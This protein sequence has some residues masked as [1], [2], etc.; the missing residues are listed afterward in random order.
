MASDEQLRRDQLLLQEQLRDLREAHIKRLHEMEELSGRDKWGLSFPCHVATTYQCRGNGYKRRQVMNNSDEIHYLFTNNYQNK[1]SIFVKLISKV[2]MRWK[3][4]GEF[5]NYESMN[6]REEDW[7]KIKTLS[8]NS[9]PEFRNFRMKLIVWMIREILRMLNQYAADYPTFSI[10]RSYFH[11]IVILAGC[12]AAMISRQTYGIR[13]VYRETFFSNP[14][15]S[16]SS[17]YPGGF[18]PWIR[19]V[20][21]HISPRAT[22]ER[23]TPDTALDPRCHSGPSARNS[24]NSN[25]GRFS[26][27]HGA[28]QQRL[29]IS[30]PHYDKFPDQQR[31]LDGRQD[32]R[33]RYVLVHNFLRN[34]CYGSKKWRWLIQWMN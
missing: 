15:A 16:S 13:T 33:L 18:D 7:S 20:T 32:S 11:L 25:E 24:F 28:D 10:N 5:K 6:F 23:Q 17:P 3:N 21:E 27:D 9:R 26:K 12:W 31:L 2:F 8:L 30:V 34:L 22:N 29:Q 1:I 19:N 14:R 4:W